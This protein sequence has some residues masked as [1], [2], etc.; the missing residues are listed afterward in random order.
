MNLNP[1]IRQTPVKGTNEEDAWSRGRCRQQLAL[2]CFVSDILVLVKSL[3][4]IGNFQTC[5]WSVWRDW[6]IGSQETKLQTEQQEVRLRWALEKPG[7]LRFKSESLGTSHW[8]DWT[9][10]PE[11][12]KLPLNRERIESRFWGKAEPTGADEV[13]A[14]GGLEDSRDRISQADH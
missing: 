11:F 2:G 13:A 10:G 12:L 4:S 1:E 8:T 5:G 3:N 9:N 14:P 7:E 6:R